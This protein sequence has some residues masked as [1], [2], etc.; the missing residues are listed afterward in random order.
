M[1]AAGK[2]GMVDFCKWNEFFPVAKGL[3]GGPNSDAFL[4]IRTDFVVQKNDGMPVLIAADGFLPPELQKITW[5]S[6]FLKVPET[7]S[8]P[9]VFEKFCG[10][11]TVGVPSPPDPDTVTLPR[12]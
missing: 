6:G 10:S 11:G 4:A 7:S 8:Q 3:V 12:N 1:L 2:K 9:G 5:K